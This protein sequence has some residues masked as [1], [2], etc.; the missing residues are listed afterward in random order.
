MRVVGERIAGDDADGAVVAEKI[1][2]VVAL[3]CMLRAKMMW[4]ESRYSQVYQ[5]TNEK[6]AQRAFV[7]HSEYFIK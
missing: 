2:G 3:S 4:F 5:I 7:S 6:T 1:N